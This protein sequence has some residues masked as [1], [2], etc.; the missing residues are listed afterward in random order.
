MDVSALE[1]AARQVLISAERSVS[2]TP[3]A[4][5]AISDTSKA[6]KIHGATFLLNL[7]PRGDSSASGS[8]NDA[9]AGAGTESGDGGGSGGGAAGGSTGFQ[10]AVRRVVSAEKVHGAAFLANFKHLKCSNLDGDDAQQQARLQIE[11]RDGASMVSGSSGGN[12]NISADGSAGEDAMGEGG[13]DQGNFDHTNRF[14]DSPLL[15]R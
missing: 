15:R 14:F 1:A 9:A 5:S 12:G 10:A 13:D 11:E 2:P 3:T 4:S 7:K 8:G 6:H